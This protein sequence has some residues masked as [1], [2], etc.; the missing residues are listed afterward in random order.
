MKKLFLFLLAIACSVAASAAINGDGECTA[1]D[2]TAVYNI[3][4]YGGTSQSD[5]TEFTVNG[6]T[7]KSLAGAS[8]ITLLSAF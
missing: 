5:V 1:S 4:L 3:I 6:V 7:F 2:V 8:A